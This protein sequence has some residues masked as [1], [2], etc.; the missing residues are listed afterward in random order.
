MSNING[1]V[2]KRVVL[3]PNVE[4]IVEFCGCHRDFSIKATGGDV[5][6]KVNWPIAGIN[7]MAANVLNDGDNFDAHE[8]EDIKSLHFLS[9]SAA[10]IQWYVR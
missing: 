8:T 6:F 1:N 7:D 3:T 2:Q 9:A 5:L 4:T 10:I